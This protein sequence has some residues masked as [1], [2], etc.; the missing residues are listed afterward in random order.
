M[1]KEEKYKQAMITLRGM[2]EHRLGQYLNTKVL[3]HYVL[4]VN[5]DYDSLAC[6][7]K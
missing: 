1:G 2:V 5:K 6:S 7:D 3:L 4:K